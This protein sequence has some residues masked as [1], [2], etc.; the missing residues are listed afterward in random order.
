MLLGIDFVI[1]QKVIT[2]KVS[3]I[4]IFSTDLV[5]TCSQH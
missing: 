2:Q 4:V 3:P 5:I 1:T